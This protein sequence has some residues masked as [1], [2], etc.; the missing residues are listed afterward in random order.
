MKPI[1]SFVLLAFLL[2][3]S[4]S[5][6]KSVETK[7]VTDTVRH[8]WQ[9]LPIYNSNGMAA[10]SSY[11]LADTT[12]VI[13]GNFGITLVPVN[14]QPFNNFFTYLLPGTSLTMP[15][16][17]APFINSRLVSYA[18]A[19]SYGVYSLAPANQFSS[20]LYTP[21]STPGAYFRFQQ[22]NTFG[23]NGS[24]SEAYPVI[25]NKYA[26][27]PVETIGTSNTQTRFDLV[28]FDSAKM[29]N[30]YPGPA[31]PPVVRHITVSS[32]PGTPG[33]F[34]SNYFCATYYNKFFVEYGGQFFRID[35]TGNVKAFG[36]TP[37]PYPNNYGVGNM[38]TVGNTLYVKSGGIIFS[39]TDQGESWS[40]VGDFSQSFPG[41]LV[42]RNVGNG[43]YAT[44][45]TLDSQLWKVVVNGNKFSFSELN[46][47]GLE[48]NLVSS[49][50]KC[51]KYVFAT[52]PTGVYYRDT[53]Y[54][55]QLKTP[56]R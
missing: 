16:Q 21:D 17:A 45:A 44:L 35:T 27:M 3:G 55:D 8:A 14:H 47:D 7:I 4:F 37:A 42:F 51:G 43:L 20:M 53:L 29:L 5:C 52:T 30:S 9:Q 50:T 33:F 32:A 49:I 41:G 40:V 36:Y 10:L 23:W 39:S 1:L 13:G 34:L 18:T 31:D 56:I 6:K 19:T 54:F 11:N 12:L 22:A 24:P 26:I 46:T 2:A 25:A 38:F 28:R 15:V 48:F